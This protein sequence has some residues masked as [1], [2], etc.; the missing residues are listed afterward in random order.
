MET[1]ISDQ[2]TQPTVKLFLKIY[3]PKI[4]RQFF[5]VRD[6]LTFGVSL[7]SPDSIW[8]ARQLRHSHL[9]HLINNIVSTTVQQQRPQLQL[10]RNADAT[11]S[12]QQ[13]LLHIGSL[14]KF[15]KIVILSS[16]IRNS[17]NA[18]NFCM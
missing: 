12:A 10:K 14:R 13:W 17:T 16:N 7:H 6:E 8:V 3:N 15:G 9:R 11:S 5:A 4:Q 18:A 2:S 1:K